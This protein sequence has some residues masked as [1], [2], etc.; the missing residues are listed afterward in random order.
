[1]KKGF[2]RISIRGKLLGIMTLL[3][4]VPSLV[5]GII[6]SRSSENSLTGQYEKFGLALGNEITRSTD[7]HLAHYSEKVESLARNQAIKDYNLDDNPA[8]AES[9]R[10]TLNLFLQN[11]EAPSVVI[12]DMNGNAEFISSEGGAR[13]ESVADKDWFK[14]TVSSGK[15]HISNLYED[16]GSQFVTVSTPIVR[17]DETVGVVGTEISME[18][19]KTM[20]AEINIGETGFPILVDG[21]GMIVGTKIDEEFGTLF[22]GVE[23]F[24]DMEE[25]YKMLQDVYVNPEGVAQEQLKFITKLKNADWKMVTIIPTGEIAEDIN[26]MMITIV[27]AGIIIVIL[28]MIA[29]ILF[30]NGFLKT[31]KKL[32]AG[33]KKMAE[34]DL[35][36]TIEIDSKDELG[37]LAENFNS[38]IEKLGGLISNVKS[39]SREVLESSSA[40]A[41]SAEATTASSEEISRT[42][43][44]IAHG[45][46]EQ[47]SDTERGVSLVTGL[48]MKLEALHSDS[49]DTLAS[50]ESI[51]RTNRDSTEVV[52]ELRK[53]TEENN[54]STSL[55]EREIVELDGDIG[56][57]GEI[58]EA[59]DSIA[60][61][62]NLL[63]LNASI[64]AA[65]AGEAG[66]G[67][68]VVAEEIR[69]LAEE[70]KSSSGDIKEIIL[71]VQDK[72]GETVKAMET[73]K[74]INSEQN[75]AVDQV[76]HSFETISTLIEEISAKL[77]EMGHSIED[78]NQDKDDVVS[79]MENI[80]SV[81][82]ETAAA[83]EEVTAS[84][85]QQSIASDK[86]S[87][88][89]E[90]L[91]AL[92]AKLIEEIDVFRVN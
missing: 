75:E 73:V 14:N 32:L 7:Q 51:N 52:T 3:V 64:E 4:I 42:V 36:E 81:S 89:A 37:E 16:S 82:Q 1:L 38:M 43:E 84:V 2:K 53:K 44:E 39:A 23:S 80:S 61:Q 67:F 88:A 86:V 30:S 71:A 9:A 47:A 50:V 60:E 58:L 54:E 12:S 90:S 13:N 48:S 87:I 83:S 85:E 70:S 69:K 6:S 78:M 34:G 49:R 27:I 28:G 57:V 21:N 22:V 63:A 45:A 11:F 91:N 46:S 76:G 77:E 33:V 10:N 40:L 41:T 92:S 72:S 62:T 56:R 74:K 66:R 20:F 24:L 18:E 19:L 26:G 8:N 5:L 65:R 79:A 59:I 68:A 55:I 29:S 15:T 25:D 31:I 17:G 35:S